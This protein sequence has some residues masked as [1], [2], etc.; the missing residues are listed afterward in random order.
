MNIIFEQRYIDDYGKISFSY[1][2]END[3]PGS[4]AGMIALSCEFGGA[5]SVYWGKDGELLTATCNEKILTYSALHTF[6]FTD[7]NQ[8]QEKKIL[9]FTAI[10]VHANCLILTNENKLPLLTLAIPQEKLLPS[11]SPRYSF[12]VIAD[13]HYNYFFNHDKTIDYAVLA[14]DRA[15][16]FYKS[17]GCAHVCAAG[18]AGKR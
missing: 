5:L 13:I 12:G 1:A 8:K 7:N 11:V 6:H 2:F 9:G 18:D 10:P 16:A 4:A 15:L 3:L 14:I 17:A